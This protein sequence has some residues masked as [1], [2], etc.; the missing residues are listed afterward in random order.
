VGIDHVGIGSDFDGVTW[1]PLGLE[2]ASKLPNLI[3][4]LLWRGYGEQDI[5]KILSGNLMRVWSEVERYAAVL[6]ERK[7][8]EGLSGI[9]VGYSPAGSAEPTDKI[10]TAAKYMMRSRYRSLPVVDENY[11][12][13]G[14]FGVNCLLKLVIPKAVFLP[15][16][17]ENVSFIHESLEE[18][19][20]RF[21][22]VKD[23]PIS[24]CMN[25]DVKPISPQTGLTETMLQLYETR[26]SIPVIEDDTCKLLGM[27]SYWDIGGNILG[28]GEST[29]A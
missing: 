25:R 8:S 5:R 16:G 21:H 19:Y 26:A 2:D 4:E 24:A 14:M 15:H 27:I 22:E 10:E 7:T 3:A 17:L 20:D 11:C 23:Q 9:P 12:Y 13:I 18:L 6:Q 1:L 29:D 28:V